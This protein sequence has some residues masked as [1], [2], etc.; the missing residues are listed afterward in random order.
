MMCWVLLVIMIYD[1]YKESS[2]FGASLDQL[3]NDCTRYLLA[4]RMKGSVPPI[5]L[6]LFFFVGCS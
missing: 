5:K 2:N 4:A 3:F 6:S 1:Y